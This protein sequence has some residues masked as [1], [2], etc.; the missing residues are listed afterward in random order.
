MNIRKHIL[1]LK[2]KLFA[3]WEYNE[4]LRL[5]EEKLDDTGEKLHRLADLSHTNFRLSASISKRMT[6]SFDKIR[7]LFLI[8][9]LNAW[10]ALDA[11]IRALRL[12]EDFDVS[13]ASVNKRFPGQSGFSGEPDVHEFL[14][15]RGIHHIRLG[16]EDSFQALDIIM[17]LSPDVIFRQ[18]QW[19]DDYPPGFSSGYLSFTRL[20]IV[21]YGICNIVENVHFKGDIKNSAVDSLFHRRCWRVYCANDE[22]LSIARRDGSLKGRQFRVVGH[23]K[24]DYLLSVKPSWPFDRVRGT[25]YRILWS[26]HHSITHGWTDFG[27]F[28]FIWRHMLAIAEKLTTVEFVFCPHPALMT[29]LSGPHSPVSEDDWK[30]FKKRWAALPGCHQYYGADYAAVA[31]AS[32]LIITDGISLLMEGQLLR[33][34]ILFTER[35]TH[36]PFNSIGNCLLKGF[37]T[38]NDADVLE[39]TVMALLSGKLSDLAA[40]QTENIERLFPVR[41]AVSNI[42]AD[43][44][45]IKY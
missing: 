25:T 24:I 39:E 30:E 32:D 16:M 10:H 38:I 35:E 2:R 31:A 6:R 41:D 12:G 42:V 7:C 37:H 11:L 36:A 43:L 18:S 21:T 8:N 19:D 22:M 33:K 17:A 44:K 27:L 1:T 3:T 14:S 28:P 9:N 26:P 5:I 15:A 45:T 4:R 29:Q 40:E 13:V 34:P 23:P 20:A